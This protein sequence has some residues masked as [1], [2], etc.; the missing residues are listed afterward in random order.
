MR[1][2][3]EYLDKISSG[4]NDIENTTHDSDSDAI[5]TLQGIRSNANKP[6]LYIIR[7]RKVEEIND[8]K[9]V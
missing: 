5:Y 6:R 7:K 1:D 4:I 3:V 2:Y 9:V 8:F